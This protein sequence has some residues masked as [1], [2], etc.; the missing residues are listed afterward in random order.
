MCKSKKEYLPVSSEKNSNLFL[1]KDKDLADNSF[2][3][4]CSTF[5]FTNKTTKLRVSCLNNAQKLNFWSPV[6]IKNNFM[7]SYVSFIANRYGWFRNYIVNPN[8]HTH[9]W[10]VDEKYPYYPVMLQA[11][12]YQKI[13]SSNIACPSLQN[14]K[15]RYEAKFKM[16]S[17]DIFVVNISQ[18]QKRTKYFCLQFWHI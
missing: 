11:K 2:L 17:S 12:S 9:F 14:E 16:S 13:F 6:F 8:F 7:M 18:L 3:M 5:Q 10:G 4:K 15:L 1:P